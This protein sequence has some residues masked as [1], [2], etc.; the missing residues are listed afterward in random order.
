MIKEHIQEFAKE[1]GR[2]ALS[3]FRREEKLISRPKSSHADIVTEA[4]EAVSDHIIDNISKFYPEHTIHSEEVKDDINPGREFRWIIDPIDGTRNFDRGLPEW[5]TMIAL[6]RKGELYMAAVYIPTHDLLFFA[7]KGKGAFRNGKQI[8]VNDV[9]SLDSASTLF[10]LSREGEDVE[11]CRKVLDKLLAEDCWL[12]NYGTMAG[13]CYLASGQ[14]DLAMNNVG[15]DYDYAAPALIAREAGA[16]V[17][18]IHGNYWKNGKRTVVVANPK[19]HS[20]LMREI[21]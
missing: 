12:F 1:G 11:L 7:E 9:S 21:L 2:L 4:D 15:F 14:I 5:C 20:K 6:E 18:D 17:T 8:N 10:V 13:I 19:L 16:L 3:Y